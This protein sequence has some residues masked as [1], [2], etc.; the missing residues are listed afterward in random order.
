MTPSTEATPADETRDAAARQEAERDDADVSRRTTV[1][2][3]VVRAVREF[4]T[5]QCTDLA[6]ALV[7]YSVLSIVPAIVA[8]VSI[9]GVL[10][11]PQSVLD[12][13]FGVI[14]DLGSAETVETLRPVLEQVATSSAAGWGLVLGL[15]TALWSASAYVTAF[16][17]DMPT[18]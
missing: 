1:R 4:M 10:A 11:D 7:Y 8:L 3:A 13:L 2:Y 12:D 18:S 17:R 5:D 9:L 16:S 14:E 15:V 6:A